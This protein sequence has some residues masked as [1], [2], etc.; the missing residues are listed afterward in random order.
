[1]PSPAA[2]LRA[3]YDDHVHN[4]ARDFGDI[5]YHVLIDEARNVY[6]GRNGDD[7]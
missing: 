6:A 7:A 5:G 4:P 2:T 1:M 3:I